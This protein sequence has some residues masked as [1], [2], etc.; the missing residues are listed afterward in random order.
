M[1]AWGDETDGHGCIQG[2]K[3]VQVMSPSRE[4]FDG[5]ERAFSSSVM[6]GTAALSILL[7][8]DIES[9]GVSLAELL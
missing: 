5:A 2:S 6:H 8:I 9:D 3:A 7:I 1:G 4:C